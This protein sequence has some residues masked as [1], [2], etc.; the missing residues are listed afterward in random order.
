MKTVVGVPILAVVSNLMQGEDVLQCRVAC[1]S[2]LTHNLSQPVVDRSTIRYNL[3]VAPQPVDLKLQ[4]LALESNVLQRAPIPLS[5][6]RR[7][8]QPDARYEEAATENEITPGL[9]QPVH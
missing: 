2:H 8:Y 6:Q 9:P 5:G 1:A 4:L 3:R 7:L